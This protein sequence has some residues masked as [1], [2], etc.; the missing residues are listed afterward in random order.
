LEGRDWR[1]LL[2]KASWTDSARESLATRRDE[3]PVSALIGLCRAR[4]I[5][6]SEKEVAVEFEGVSTAA[7]KEFRSNWKVT[8]ADD[9]GGVVATATTNMNVRAEGVPSP[10]TAILKIPLTTGA[11]P[12][13]PLRLRADGNIERMTGMYHGHGLWMRLAEK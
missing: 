12:A 4:V 13:R 9:Q 10:F 7:W 8:L 3:K 1:P 11:S 6:Q 5:E 2:L